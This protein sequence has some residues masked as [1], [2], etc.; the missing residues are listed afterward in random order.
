MCQIMEYLS[1]PPCARLRVRVLAASPH[2]IG[3]LACIMRRSI[4]IMHVYCYV[5][6]SQPHEEAG[7]QNGNSVAVLNKPTNKYRMLSS[8][9]RS[10]RQVLEESLVGRAR[11]HSR[12]P[13]N[14][15]YSRFAMRYS[16]TNMQR[17]AGDR[18]IN[19]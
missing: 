7:T 11:M 15:A 10:V 18:F 12:E 3:H 14:N 5:K 16:L 13:F 1:M 19:E 6:H 17:N 4:R 2:G 9:L 8:S